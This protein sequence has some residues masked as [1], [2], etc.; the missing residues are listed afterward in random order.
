MGI[1]AAASDLHPYNNVFFKQ[2]LYFHRWLINPRRDFRYNSLGSALTHTA[3][4][5]YGLVGDGKTPG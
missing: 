5:N 3:F 1:T 2:G 4:L